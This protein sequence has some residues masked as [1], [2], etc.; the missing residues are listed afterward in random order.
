[1][2]LLYRKLAPKSWLKRQLKV[3]KLCPWLHLVW[4]IATFGA[5]SQEAFPNLY[6]IWQ[7]DLRYFCQV[8][9]FPHRCAV[10]MFLGKNNSASKCNYSNWRDTYA[11]VSMF[12]SARPSPWSGMRY[13]LVRG[14]QMFCM[15]NT[16]SPLMS[17]QLHLSRVRND[18]LNNRKC[19]RILGRWID[20]TH[21][22][23][24]FH[25]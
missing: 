5:Y 2:H 25:T 13:G 16:K 10:V 12:T 22:W 15:T 6:E 9:C 17:A 1:M 11:Q 24:D 18:K 23:H 8:L 19:Y 3:L 14:T 20:K 21:A 4:A 7:A